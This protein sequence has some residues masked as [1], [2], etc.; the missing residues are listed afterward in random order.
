MNQAFRE[1]R[2]DNSHR[3]RPTNIIYMAA[4]CSIRDFTDTAGAYLRSPDGSSANFYNLCLHPRR[5][6]D[7]NYSAAVRGSLLIWIDNIFGNPTN[8]EDRTLGS[9]IN[10]TLA[11]DLLPSNT[12]IKGFGVNHT[13]DQQRGPQSHGSFGEFKWWDPAFY[14][15]FTID[16]AKLHSL[17]LAPESCDLPTEAPR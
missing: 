17:R 1:F 15:D 4:A 8:F 6:V 2:H 13:R 3:L 7:E 16:P 10:C 9:F 11:S 12:F 5:E 14:G